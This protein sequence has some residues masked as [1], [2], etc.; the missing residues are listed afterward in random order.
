MKTKQQ[1][2]AELEAKLIGHDDE[3]NDTGYTAEEQVEL[4]EMNQLFYEML[5]QQKIGLP[6]W[7][8]G[9]TPQEHFGIDTSMYE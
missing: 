3:N 8:A 5:V 6:S 9:K 1:R 4:R 7:F 2:Y